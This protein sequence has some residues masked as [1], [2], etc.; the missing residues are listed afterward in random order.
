[1]VTG[2]PSALVEDVNDL[3]TEARL[4]RLLDAGVGHGRGGPVDCRV[5]IDVPAAQCPCGLRIRLGGQRA[6]GGT[7]QGCAHALAGAGELLARSP[8]EGHQQ[9]GHRGGQLLEGA[10]GLV[11]EPCQ[12]PALHHLH[13]HLDLGCI[14]GTGGAGRDEGH[15]RVRRELGRGP[16]AGGL[17]ARGPAHGSL[18]MIRAHDLGPPT[19]RREGTDMRPDPIGQTLAPGRCGQGRVGSAQHSDADRGCADFPREG[20]D[21]RQRLAG[22]V[23][24]ERLARP[25]TRPHD[26]S[27]LPR[28]LTIRLTTWTVLAAIGGAGLVCVPHQEHGAPLTCALLV[29][30]GPVRCGAPRSGCVGGRRTQLSL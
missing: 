11:A 3:R 14:P 19:E 13:A 7:V 8:V 18:E 1:L 28:P 25:G 9:V 22:S 24:K 20:I 23:D 29:S 4:E 6:E 10:A 26:Q 16:G 12:A 27:E 15:V 2:H 21:D 5:I 30:D 17:R